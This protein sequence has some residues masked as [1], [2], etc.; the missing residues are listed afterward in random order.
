MKNTS[1]TR[2]SIEME[3]EIKTEVIEIERDDKR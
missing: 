2:Q 3:M 1:F